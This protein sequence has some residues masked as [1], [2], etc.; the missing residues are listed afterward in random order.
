MLYMYYIF[1]EKWR[2]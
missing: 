1:R 2:P